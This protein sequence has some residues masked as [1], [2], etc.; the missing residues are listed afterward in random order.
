MPFLLKYPTSSLSDNAL[1]WLAEGFYTQKKYN[2]AVVK[3]QDLVEKFPKSDKRCDAMKRQVQCLTALDMKREAEAFKKVRSAECKRKEVIHILAFESSCD[4]TSV[5]VLRAQVGDEMPQLLSLSV[6]S[7][8]DVH[9]K[10]GGVVPELASRAHLSNIIPCVR[11]VLD[12]AQ[13]S[14]GAN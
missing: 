11:K 5:A 9:E 12:E 14:L 13:I 1:F 10:Y 3:F 7:Q 8:W 6:Q 4:E 2:T